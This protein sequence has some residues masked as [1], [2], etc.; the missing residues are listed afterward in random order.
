MG[1]LSADAES[2]GPIKNRRK[3]FISKTLGFPKQAYMYVRGLN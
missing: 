3:K 1:G 2:Q